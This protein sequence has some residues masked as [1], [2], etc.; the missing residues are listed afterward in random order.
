[1]RIVIV[2]GSMRHESVTNRVALCLHNQLTQ[3]KLHSDIIDVREINLPFITDG[4]ANKEAVPDEH[5]QWAN[6]MFEADAVIMLTPEYN[7][8]YTPSLKNVF[9]HFPKQS[10]KAFGIVTASPG[11]L[12]GIRAAMQMQQLV[13]A[14]FGILSPYMLVIPGVDKKFD[15]QGTLIDPNFQKSI[16]LFL[17]EFLWLAT[18]LKK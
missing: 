4:F 12:G 3:L 2:S 13:P 17:R 8:S 10:R 1:M 11:G 16:D 18:Q 15:E 14:L 6:L 9:D 7:G 5:K